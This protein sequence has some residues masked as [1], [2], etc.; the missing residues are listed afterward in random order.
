[1]TG[2]NQHTAHN[3]LKERTLLAIG[4]RD[5]LLVWNAPAGLFRTLRGNGVV[6]VGLTGQADVM[7]VWRHPLH[8][9]GQTVAFEM[10]TGAGRL[11]PEQ[12][13]WRDQFEA[14][15]GLYVPVRNPQD[16]VNALDD[17]CVIRKE[18]MGDIILAGATAK[19]CEDARP[20]YLDE[21]MAALSD[22]EL[23]QMYEACRDEMQRRG[24]GSA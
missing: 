20:A 2:R 18:I 15:G 8:G 1:M 12:R 13:L 7:G 21:A 5:D 9:I 22:E 19:D 11:S 10:K 14:R 24:L 3:E 16:A 23:V 4:A 17:V 6:R